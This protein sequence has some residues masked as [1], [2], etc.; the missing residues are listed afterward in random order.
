MNKKSSDGSTRWKIERKINRMSKNRSRTSKSDTKSF[1][2]KKEMQNKK[3]NNKSF[4]KKSKNKHFGLNILLKNKTSRKSGR[5]S[6]AAINS[7]E[8]DEEKSPEVD[9][10]VKDN[11][12]S[13]AVTLTKFE[14]K[15]HPN[16]LRDDKESTESG[17]KNFKFD[18]FKKINIRKDAGSR[19]PFFDR[20]KQDRS[21]RSNF[22]Q[23]Q[24]DYNGV[25]EEEDWNDVIESKEIDPLRK[26]STHHIVFSERVA[27][28]NS[29]SSNKKATTDTKNLSNTTSN[30]KAKEENSTTRNKNATT[31]TKTSSKNTSKS[32]NKTKEENSTSSGVDATANV[33]NLSNETQS[34]KTKGG[35]I[36]ISKFLIQCSKTYNYC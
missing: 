9:N 35:R 29:T 21:N 14:K 26:P 13:D 25:G 6:G 31:D 10:F 22:D 16:I 12:K 3:K 4:F 34:N 18:T 15:T 20:V 19:F 1:A 32:N 2:V 17:R 7:R 30:N 28:E 23:I 24:D 8:N 11:V 27:E 33:T 36:L 5:S